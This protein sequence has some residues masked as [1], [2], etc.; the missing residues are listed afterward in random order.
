MKTLT[1]LFKRI[2]QFLKSLFTWSDVVSAIPEPIVKHR[3]EAT[4]SAQAHH[5]NSYSRRPWTKDEEDY[6]TKNYPDT[7][8]SVLSVCLNRSYM[9]IAK[10]AGKLGLKK[11]SEFFSA[12]AIQDETIETKMARIMDMQ[13]QIGDFSV[14]L[15]YNRLAPREERCVARYREILSTKVYHARCKNFT[16]A[17]NRIQ[18]YITT[19]H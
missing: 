9:S 2:W 13:K 7:K 16:E 14:D 19:S 17:L 6:L 3:T 1:N 4:R 10:K 5:V 18:E 8:D 12:C 15:Y 11:S